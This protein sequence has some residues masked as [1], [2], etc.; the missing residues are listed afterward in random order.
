MIKKNKKA[1][2]IIEIL[3]WIVIFLFWIAWVYSIISS[4]LNINN[5]NK[6]YI[7]WVN[8]AREQLELFRNIRDVNFSKIQ[9]FNIIDP[10]NSWCD[11]DWKCIVFE[12]WKTYKISNDF[13]WTGFPVKVKEWQK[14]DTKDSN[15]LKEYQVCLDEEG[16]YDYCEGMT[17][18][19]KELKI[20]KFLEVSKVE[21]YEPSNALKVTSKMVWYSK[22]YNEF[23]V[24]TIFTNYKIY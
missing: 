24:S 18:K 3:V 12:E 2:S 15:S 1:F 5:Y 16:L 13:S 21:W 10:N 19:K 7:I 14:F 6:N 11:N 20:Y 8:L 4:T 22:K 9:T 17:N 23:E